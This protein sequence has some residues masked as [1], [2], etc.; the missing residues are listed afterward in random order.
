MYWKVIGA[1]N[2]AKTIRSDKFLL[3]QTSQAF[4]RCNSWTACKNSVPGALSSIFEVSLHT[5]C[6]TPDY[7]CARWLSDPRAEI[8]D[9]CISPLDFT[10]LHNQVA[11]LIFV[12]TSSQVKSQLCSD[13]EIM[14]DLA[15]GNNGLLDCMPLRALSVWREAVA[16]HEDRWRGILQQESDY[17]RNCALVVGTTIHFIFSRRSHILEKSGRSTTAIEQSVIAYSTEH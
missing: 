2:V 12:N 16:G 10:A 1:E 3:S 6:P 5:K 13:T 15:W 11:A 7:R 8:A 17:D 4:H 14:S 9:F